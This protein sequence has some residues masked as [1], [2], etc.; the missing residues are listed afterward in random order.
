M[1]KTCVCVCVRLIDLHMKFDV[2]C[3]Q[4]SHAYSI[5]QALEEGGCACASEHCHC[6]E[7]IYII[8]NCSILGN[9]RFYLCY[10]YFRLVIW[11]HLLQMKCLC[12]Y[13]ISHWERGAK[14]QIST[15]KTQHYV[16]NASNRWIL[17]L[18]LNR[19]YFASCR[20]IIK[21]ITSGCKHIID[22]RCWL[23]ERA[24]TQLTFR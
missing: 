24:H 7:D 16:K 21:N 14:Y 19:W 12:N 20:T 22:R 4:S 9:F 2:V 13:Q 6:K 3:P 8:G 5:Q 17:A 18:L 15:T 23:S 1:C 11:L 10:K